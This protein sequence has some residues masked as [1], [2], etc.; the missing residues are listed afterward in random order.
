MKRTRHTTDEII[1]KLREA[2]QLAAGGHAVSSICQKV[3]VNA[4][5]LAR[6]RQHF[7]GMVVVY[8]SNV[9]RCSYTDHH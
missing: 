7:R 8:N 6:R 5:A 2:D 3:V 1:R 9:P 4:Q